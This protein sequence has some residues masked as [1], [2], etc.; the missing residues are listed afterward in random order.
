MKFYGTFS[1]IIGTYP[2][3]WQAKEIHRVLLEY[4]AEE[5][6]EI[7]LKLLKHIS[8]ITWDNVIVYGE[9]IINK[10]WIKL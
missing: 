3:Y 2:I 1:P 4:P 8:P 10:D 9:Y 7:D 6:L 5:S